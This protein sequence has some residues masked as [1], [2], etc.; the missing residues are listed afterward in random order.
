MDRTLV[1]RG[2]AALALALVLTLAGA[3]P[4]AAEEPG[5]WGTLDRLLGLWEAEGNGSESLWDIV[6]GWFEKTS[7]V[8]DEERG[9]G[10]DPNGNSLRISGEPSESASPNP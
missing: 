7:F 4:V 10:L 5:F 1:R 3:Q 6:G 2:L 9:A 8:P